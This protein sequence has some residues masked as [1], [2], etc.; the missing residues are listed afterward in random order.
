MLQFRILAGTAVALLYVWQPKLRLAV[1]SSLKR[2][3]AA[4]ERAALRQ[5]ATLSKRGF[6]AGGPWFASLQQELT[7]AATNTVDTDPAKYAGPT[8][9]QASHGLPLPYPAISDESEAIPG[10]ADLVVLSLVRQGDLVLN[11]GGGAFDGGPRWLEQQLSGVRVLTA[12][13]FRRAAEHNAAVQAAVVAAGG[14]NVVVSIS[15]LNVIAEHTSRIDHIAL[16]Y[17][18]L[19]PGGI[20]YFKVWADLWPDRGLSRGAADREMGTFQVQA[21]ADYYLPEVEA[22]FGGQSRCFADC[23]RNMLVAIKE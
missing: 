18:S 6:A 17:H 14:A 9:Y 11:L 15:V 21:W 12:D 5:L 23:T 4:G 20:A 22:V 7:S 19:R 3:L 1:F 8:I 13:P 16:A 2:I 10:M